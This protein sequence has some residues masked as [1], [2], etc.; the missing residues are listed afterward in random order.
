MAGR[1]KEGWGK[2]G[3]RLTNL[4]FWPN[5]QWAPFRHGIDWVDGQSAV[6]IHPHTHRK[7]TPH[8]HQPTKQDQQREK[9]QDKARMSKG[10]ERVGEVVRRGSTVPGLGAFAFVFGFG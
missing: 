1:G 6:S 5:E 8:V 4:Q 9:A 7:H 10:A 3:G 2:Q